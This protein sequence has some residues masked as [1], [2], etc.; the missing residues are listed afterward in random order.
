[1]NKPVTSEAAVLTQRERELGAIISAY[2]DVTERLKTAHERLNDEVAG[3]REELRRKNAELRRRERLA[4]LGE[5][6][7]GLAHE[8]RNPLGGIALY[9]SQLEKD[10]A[11]RPAA[12]AA[13]AKISQGVR[14][15]EQLVSR[16]LDFAQEYEIDRQVCPLGNI[17]EAVEDTV[18]A[19]AAEHNVEVVI[20]PSA[21]RV[22]V[23]CDATRLRQVIVN[24]LLN[25]IQSAGA[26]GHV[27]LVARRL[28][29]SAD[30]DSGSTE[31]VLIEVSDDGPG[32]AP[33]VLDKIFNPFFTT[34]PTG[35]G[36]GLA[37]VHQ[38]IEAHDGTIRAGN[39]REGG[40]RFVLRLPVRP[41]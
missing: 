29:A 37:I 28:P 31:A 35:M 11:D 21:A 23:Y 6:A 3:L 27:W 4:A 26:G 17:L 15:L 22:E 19:W 34:R 12:K 32:I 25:G 13:A 39:R 5:M 2:N 8:V 10:L 40:A 18:R 24:L 33:E 1:M 36:L 30:R 9:A 38:I 20:E 7:A 16:I 14:S 41:D